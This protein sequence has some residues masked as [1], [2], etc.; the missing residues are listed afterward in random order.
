[1][2]IMAIIDSMII[3]LITMAGIKI[4]HLSAIKP[5]RIGHAP[6]AVGD[7]HCTWS[8]AAADGAPP[9]G[10]RGGPDAVD[11][12]GGACR[13]KGRQEQETGP[14]SASASA[15]A[16][17]KCVWYSRQRRWRCSHQWWQCS[18][19]WWRWVAG[20]AEWIHRIQRYCRVQAGPQTATI[21]LRDT[22]GDRTVCR[23]EQ[24]ARR[25]RSYGRQ[26]S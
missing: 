6:S 24:D 17:P 14:T 8:A 9:S 20:P 18:Y 12:A 21:R 16:P 25:R 26:E 22:S 19:Q 4:Y 10:P 7:A 11:V 13:V 1:M 5:S 3:M 23:S 15:S 2:V